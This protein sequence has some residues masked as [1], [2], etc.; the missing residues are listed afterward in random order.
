MGA[1]RS[2]IVRLLRVCMM[3]GLCTMKRKDM[4]SQLLSISRH[5]RA[6]N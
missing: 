3:G 4:H 6:P 2:T 1:L 5:R